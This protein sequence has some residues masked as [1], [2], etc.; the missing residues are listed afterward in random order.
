MGEYSL[1]KTGEYPRIFPSFQNRAHCEKDLKDIKH[2][3]LHLGRKYARIFVLVHYLFLI[4]HRFPIKRSLKTV[5]Y[6]E[7][8]MSADKYPSLFF[9]QA[10]EWAGFLNPQISLANHAH[11]TGPAFYNTAHGPDFFPTA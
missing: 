2:N 9:F 7:Q 3:S 1:A 4:V 11:V 10:S 5:R 8:I 6:L